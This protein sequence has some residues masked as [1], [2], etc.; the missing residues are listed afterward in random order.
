MKYSTA[1][2]GRKLIIRKPDGYYVDGKCYP[3]LGAATDAIGAVR[4]TAK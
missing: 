1:Q 2:Y 4:V 3:T